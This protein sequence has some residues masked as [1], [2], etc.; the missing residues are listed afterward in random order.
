[1][2]REEQFACAWGA[3]RV[4]AKDRWSRLTSR[5]LD[6]VRRNA[7]LLIGMIEGKYDEPRTAIEMQIARF[8][9]RH[10]RPAARP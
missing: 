5:D 4:H 2:D 10:G 8:L 9:V 1:M 7:A 3:I 6:Q